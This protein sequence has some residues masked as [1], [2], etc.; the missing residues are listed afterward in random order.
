VKR[1]IIKATTKNRKGDK[2]MKFYDPKDEAD[3]ARVEELLKNGGIEYSVA[4]ARP[5]AATAKEINVAEEDVPKAE[6]IMEGAS[7]GFGR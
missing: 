3:L 1:T 6:E 4:A 7:K 5:G 2:T